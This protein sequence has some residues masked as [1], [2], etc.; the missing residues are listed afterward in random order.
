MTGPDPRELAEA[1]AEAHMARAGI[2][3]AAGAAVRDE[4]VT[5]YLPMAGA[6]A[7]GFAAVADGIGA[8]T[9]KIGRQIEKADR[10]LARIA[11]QDRAREEAAAGLAAKI[12][13][14]PGRPQFRELAPAD[15]HKLR[16]VMAKVAEMDAEFA[17]RMQQESG[18]A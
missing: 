16:M 1:M 10:V 14:Q 9:A 3:K 15:L 13:G 4:L 17:A 2:T 8:S 18:G 7:D 11:E 5:A 6:I 12:A